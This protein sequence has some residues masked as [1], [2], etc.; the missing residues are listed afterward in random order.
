MDAGVAM[1]WVFPMLCGLYGIA[2]MV[3]TRRYQ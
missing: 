3:L 1:I 2:K